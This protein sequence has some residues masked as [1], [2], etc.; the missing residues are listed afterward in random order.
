MKL[1][2]I[3]QRVTQRYGRVVEGILRKH[4]GLTLES[5]L[6][7]KLRDKVQAD[8]AQ[9][10]QDPEMFNAYWAKLEAQGMNEAEIMALLNRQGVSHLRRQR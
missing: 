4:Y 3:A 6:A 10:I 9:A 1:E 2:E 8:F 5:R 7:G